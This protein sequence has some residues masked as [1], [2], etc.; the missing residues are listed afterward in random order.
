METPNNPNNPTPNLDDA[1]PT[2]NPNW[3]QALDKVMHTSLMA[4]RPHALT[5]TTPQGDGHDEEDD[6]LTKEDGDE[7][8][9]EEVDD[10]YSVSQGGDEYGAEEE[11][12]EE[13][14]EEE[15]GDD[16]DEDDD[17]RSQSHQTSRRRSPPSAPS[18]FSR[19]PSPPKGPP[20]R[21]ADVAAAAAAAAASR[22]SMPFVPP[23]VIH[24]PRDPRMEATRKRLEENQTL[25]KEEKYELLGRLQYLTDEKG[26]K[27]FRILGPDDTLEDIRYEVFRANREM[28][29]KRNVKMM[30]KALVTVGAGV[31]M[32]NS[33]YNP[34][35]LR[36]DGFS[37]SLLLSIREYD[38][39][40]EE[41]HWKYCDSVAMPP[42]M[43]LVMTL[44][45]SLW[46]FH[47]SNHSS[48]PPAAA[49]TPSPS[50]PPA[51]TPTPTPS[52][53]TQRRMNG[54]RMQQRAG[55]PPPDMNNNVMGGP[56]PAAMD[57]NSL[58][59]GLGMVQTLMTAGAKF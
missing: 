14:E 56:S 31:E 51:P 3:Q 48:I 12:E 24:A 16:F 54:P 34:L 13:G 10:V 15:M 26:F 44:G 58:L 42:E 36:L 4:S 47:M 23:S 50:A 57:M 41:L 29:K 17:Q 49:E 30:Q 33:W 32:M 52:G 8:E 37:K 35:K 22:P 2:I 7:D 45:S 11:E 25:Q 55:S 6:D 21:P 43:K 20:S 39:I 5:N 38:E 19:G 59:S 53:T 1:V 18:S 40:F 28:T 9:L 46:F 27:P